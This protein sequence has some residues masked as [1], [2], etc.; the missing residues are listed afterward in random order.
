[1]Y[2]RDGACVITGTGRK[3]SHAAHIIPY[4]VGKSQARASTDLWTVLRMFWGEDE[5]SRLQSLIFGPPTDP[6]DPNARTLVNQLYNVITI[7]AQAHMFWGHGYFVLEPHPEDN[8][9]DTLTQRAVFY[10]VYP[11]PSS[12]VAPG[13]FTPIPLTAELPPVT[14][15]EPDEEVSLFFRDDMTGQPRFVESGHIVTFRTDDPVLKPLPSRELLWLQCTL[16]RILR[17]AGRAGWDMQEMNY[18]ERDVDSIHGSLGGVATLEGGSTPSRRH[19]DGPS[20]RDKGSK[21]LN[22]IIRCG[23]KQAIWPQGRKLF[24]YVRE[25]IVKRLQSGKMAATQN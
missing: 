19:S 11:H 12:R 20:G 14:D 13:E 24:L 15:I 4:S 10:W 6:P 18:S 23:A 22:N 5:I 8:P 1:M 25:V 7:S 3:G 21:V 9:Q 2:C 16:V 17:M